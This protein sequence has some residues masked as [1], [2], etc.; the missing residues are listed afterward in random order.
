MVG[1]RDFVYC[2]VSFCLGQ[3]MWGVWWHFGLYIFH[4]SFDIGFWD[5]KVG[6]FLDWVFMY[7]PSYFGCDSNGG[8]VF[9]PWFYRLWIDGSYLVCLRVRAWSGN[10]SWQYVDSISW[11]VSAGEGVIGVCVWF[12]APSM[13]KCLAFVWLGI[14]RLI[15]GM[16]IWGATLGLFV[17]VVCCWECRHYRSQFE[18]PCLFIDL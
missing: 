5:F 15:V 18:E 16:C 1:G 8:L 11:I 6:E 4:M 17:L 3:G 2:Q 7:S 9:Q 14:A 13:H 12:G 10:L